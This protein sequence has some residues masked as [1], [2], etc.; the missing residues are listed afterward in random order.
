MFKGILFCSATGQLIQSMPTGP[1]QGVNISYNN[2]GQMVKWTR[3]HVTIDMV[4]DDK[5]GQLIER[6]YGSRA[7]Y[8]YIYK[9][10]TKVSDNRGELWVI[11]GEVWSNER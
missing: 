7:L 5:H 8:R 6:H 1:V 11:I 3:G 9:T 10:G 2:H 4:Y